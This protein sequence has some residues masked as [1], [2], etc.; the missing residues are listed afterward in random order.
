MR[1]FATIL[2]LLVLA[3][4]CPV[5][6]QETVSP[7]LPFLTAAVASPEAPCPEMDE[8]PA[9]LQAGGVLLPTL[10]CGSCSLN[11]CANRRHGAGCY[12]SS[13][14][15]GNCNDMSAALCSDGK[16]KCYCMPR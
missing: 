14:E 1:T 12:T 13:G 15:P 8:T 2:T 10:D 11:G 4:I 6:A 3:V 16:L 5:E 7:D 9:F